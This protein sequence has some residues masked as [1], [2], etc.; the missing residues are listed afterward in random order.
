MAQLAKNDA[1]TAAQITDQ[2]R[3]I[4]FRNLLIHGYAGVN[5][6][7]VWDVVQDKLST[8][9]TEVSSRLNED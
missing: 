1:Q 3:I 2:R 9:L 8:L 7:V 5:N 4:D 6:D